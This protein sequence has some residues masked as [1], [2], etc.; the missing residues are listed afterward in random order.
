MVNPGQYRG[1]SHA[2]MDDTTKI[3]LSPRELELVTSAEWILT[4]N[5]VIKKAQALLGE[6]QQNILDYS[7]LKAGIF[8]AEIMAIPPKISRGENYR[9]LPWLMLDHPRFFGSEKQSGHQEIF[10]IRTMFWWAN[11]FSSTVHLSGSFKERYAARILSHFKEIGENEFYVSAGSHQ[12][13]HHFEP[14]NYVPVSA[15][16]YDQFQQRVNGTAFLKL[17]RKLLLD[18]WQG[19]IAFLTQN[20]VTITKWLD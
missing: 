18:K 16:A 4:K 10:A 15:L 11:F 14:D 13:H 9:G 6:V 17:S 7:R 3:H 12:W 5:L 19:A 1:R 20:F 8:P 2:Y